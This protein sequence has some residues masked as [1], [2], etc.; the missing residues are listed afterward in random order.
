MAH[1]SLKNKRNSGICWAK[2]LTGFKLNA[3]YCNIAQHGVQTNAI[4]C[5]QHVGTT[6]CVRLH[7]LNIGLVKRLAGQFKVNYISRI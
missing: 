1:R 7:V 4:C 5:A 2:S 3:T 6:C